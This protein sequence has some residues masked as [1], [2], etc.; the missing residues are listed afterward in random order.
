MTSLDD[1]ITIRDLRDDLQVAG[2]YMDARLRRARQSAVSD[3]ISILRRP[4]LE[5]ELIRMGDLGLLRF[6]GRQGKG[7]WLEHW[8]VRS[9]EAVKYF[10]SDAAVQTLDSGDLADLDKADAQ[11]VQWVPEDF[12]LPDDF[13]TGWRVEF[14]VGVP[15]DDDEMLAAIR[16]SVVLIAGAYIDQE[17]DDKGRG[18]PAARKAVH[19]IL[20][21]WS[22]KRLSEI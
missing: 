1:I 6:R 20:Q 2:G 3:C 9:V 17:A 4:I 8:D 16:Q 14:T 21:S 15:D 13:R 19:S 12:T 10:D 11:A 5:A 22:A 18:I 7:F